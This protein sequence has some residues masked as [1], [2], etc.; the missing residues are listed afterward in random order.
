MIAPSDS[1][2]RIL[3]ILS[4]DTNKQRKISLFIN[5]NYQWNEEAK[6]I[7][8]Y[9]ICRALLKSVACTKY[10]WNI[11]IEILLF[12]GEVTRCSQV[13]ITKQDQECEGDTETAES[14]SRQW[15]QASDD[16]HSLAFWV[17]IITFQI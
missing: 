10:F 14:W 17:V 11:F 4:P 1:Q 13:S 8:L 3:T 6:H 5:Y 16:K 7:K 2:L 9:Y 15:L 12:V